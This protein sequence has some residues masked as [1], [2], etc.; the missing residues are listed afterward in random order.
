SRRGTESYRE[1]LRNRM[2]KQPRPENRQCGVARENP[3]ERADRDSIIENE[4]DGREAG[5]NAGSEREESDSRIVNE[6]ACRKDR[7]DSEREWRPRK[8]F[9][10][11]APRAHQPLK[12]VGWIHG[13]RD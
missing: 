1:Q 6:Q 8:E 9:L 5:E 13:R 2:R 11:L 12:I 7:F 4:D 10:A 3:C